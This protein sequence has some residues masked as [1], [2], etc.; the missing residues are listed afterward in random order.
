MTSPRNPQT[1]DLLVVDDNRVNR[2]LL[3]RA[4]EQLVGEYEIVA[5]A[6]EELRRALP[7]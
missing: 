2:L 7:A 1:G 5:S 4:L 6:L 3:G